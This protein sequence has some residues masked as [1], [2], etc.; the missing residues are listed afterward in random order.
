MN[1]L[2][3]NQEATFQ[4]PLKD[5]S[6]FPLPN[7]EVSMFK[8][9]YPGIDVDGEIGKMIAWA[10]S[11]PAQRKTKRGV[12]RFV[13]GWLNRSKPSQSAPASTTQK[14]YAASTTMAER[15]SDLSWADGL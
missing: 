15:V 11:N 9:A 10:V 14:E 13:N 8:M 7:N 6:L 2:V 3:I 1:Q 12:L 4:I 5:G